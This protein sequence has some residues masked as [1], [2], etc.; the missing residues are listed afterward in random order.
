MTGHQEN[1]PSSSCRATYLVSTRSADNLKIM[2]YAGTVL[3]KVGSVL[4]IHYGRVK[5]SKIYVIACCSMTRWEKYVTH[6]TFE[7][8]TFYIFHILPFDLFQVYLS[9]LKPRYTFAMP[10]NVRQVGA[11]SRIKSDS[12]LLEDGCEVE[13]DTILMCTGYAYSYPFLDDKCGITVG[14]DRITPLYKHLIHTQYPTLCIPSITK[15]SLPFPHVDHQIRFFLKTLDGSMVLPSKDEMD[16]DIR[17]DYERRLESGMPHRYA[18]RMGKKLLR[19]YHTDLSQLSGIRP[20]PPVIFNMFEYGLDRL[21]GDYMNFKN[22]SF[23]IID[24][25]KFESRRET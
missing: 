10:S 16:A 15:I 11:I 19:E 5:H 13:V 25:E 23:T 1:S 12:V 17:A 3:T 8:Y 7:V 9:H 2:T 22:D 6:W 14:R 18:H 24:D 4:L 20:I 21:F